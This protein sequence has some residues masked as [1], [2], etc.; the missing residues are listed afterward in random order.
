MT[1]NIMAKRKRTNNDLLSI[2]QKIKD[3]ATLT[4]L[5]ILAELRCWERGTIQIRYT[6]S[7]CHNYNKC[8]GLNSFQR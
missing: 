4:P 6:R 2:T 8:W 5:K 7:G 3:R 1:E